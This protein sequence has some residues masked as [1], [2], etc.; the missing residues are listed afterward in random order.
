M[1]PL[2]MF[3]EAIERI[4]PT[5]YAEPW[6]NV[7]LLAGDPAQATSRAMLCIDYTPEVAAE[8]RSAGCDLV[9]AYHPPIFSPLKRLG[10]ENLI[11][12]AIRRGVA[13]Y[14]P[15]T[16][17]DIAPGGT[18]DLLADSIGI[19]PDSRRP[20]RPIESKPSHYKLITFLPEGDVERVADSLWRAGAGQIGNYTQCSFRTPGQGTFLGQSGTRPAVGQAEQ[21]QRT[22][23]IKLEV[24]VPSARLPDALAALRQAHP[25][26]EPA[27]DL[28]QLAPAPQRLGDAMLGQGRIGPLPSPTSRAQIIDRIKRALSLDHVLIAGPINGQITRAACCAGSCGDLLDDALAARAELYLTGEM[29]HHDA[30]KAAAK[31]MTVVCTLHSN[32]ERAVLKRVADKLTTA[33]PEI[34]FQMSATDRDPFTIL[35]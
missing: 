13:I 33:L 17:L 3:I 11:F 22:P 34:S 28:L 9:I 4:A 6:D 1:T 10:P 25:Y 23:E 20:L 5:R 7:G 8:A 27:L 15:H 18:N 12:D 19:P 29:R 2:N 24:I 32:S 16:A 35:P 31:G 30:L 21:F 26:E 14:A